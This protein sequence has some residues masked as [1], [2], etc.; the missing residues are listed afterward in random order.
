MSAH[1]LPHA[2]EE[3]A[4]P[5]ARQYIVIAVILSVITAVEVAIYYVPSIR[6]IITPILILLSAVKFSIVVMYYMHLKFDARLFTTMFLFGLAMA[7]FTIIMFIAL[8]HGLVPIGAPSP[9][10]PH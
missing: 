4:H 9:A 2:P 1:A 5:G 7:A 10:A 3:H 6:P 8:F